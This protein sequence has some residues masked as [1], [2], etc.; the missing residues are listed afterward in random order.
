ML[1]CR[2][3]PMVLLA[4]TGCRADRS[5]DAIN[6]PFTVSGARV[7][8][9][10][11]NTYLAAH[12]GFTSRGG[13]MRCAYTPLGQHGTRVFVRALCTELVAVDG[14][15]VNGSAM[16]LPAAFEIV[17][18]GSRARVAGVEVPRDG[19]GYAASIRRIF[20]AATWPAIFANGIRDQAI[21]RLERQLRLEAAARLGLPPAAARAPRR[22]DR[23]PLVAPDGGVTPVSAG[24]LDSAARRMVEFLHG[25]ASLDPMDLSD[26][27]TL[28]VAP[29]GGGGSAAF[30]RD[31]LRDRS[32]WK[33]RSGGR[34]FTLAP[35]TGVTKLTTSVGSHFDCTEQPLASKSPRLARWP[36]VGTML[37]PESAASCLQSWNV[38][39][40]FDVRNSRPRVVAAMY[41]Q[42]EW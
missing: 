41:D 35:P 8:P 15:L 31:Q 19:D 23:P 6:T 39:F 30:G 27:V 10:S 2:I 32:A 3:A 11:L 37:R 42:W 17:V 25:H 26:T 9:E 38:T 12:R 4:C 40:V 13:E 24:T 14:A 21:V 29:E 5:P 36:H 20:P 28:W 1:R 33:V 18:E 34:V 22:H 16:N 7:E